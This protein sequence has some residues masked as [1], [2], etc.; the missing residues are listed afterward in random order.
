MYFVH[1]NLYLDIKEGWPFVND[2]DCLGQRIDDGEYTKD[3]RRYNSHTTLLFVISTFY[4]TQP[5]NESLNAN[6]S[7]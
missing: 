4:K 6:Y 7:L 1:L 5:F 2:E 3:R